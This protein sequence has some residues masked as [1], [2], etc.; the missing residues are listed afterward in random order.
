M[1]SS[2][3][4][5]NKEGFVLVAVLAMGI[6]L[7]LI[8]TSLYSITHLDTLITANKRRHNQASMAAKSGINHFMATD[9]SAN[10]VH[11]IVGD[12]DA[13]TI[14]NNISMGDGKTYY[15]VSVATCC[16]SEG[17][18]LPRDTFFVISSGRRTGGSGE[19]CAKELATV[20]T[21][22]SED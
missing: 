16:D 12:G 3:S 22:H 19:A 6:F 2:T 18:R 4:D 14:L 7:T 21:M 10:E 9:M 1:K 17:R 15:S 8:A 5:H 20:R 13:K 11:N